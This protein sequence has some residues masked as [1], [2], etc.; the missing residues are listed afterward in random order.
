MNKQAQITMFIIVGLVILLLAIIGYV[1]FETDLI[2]KPPEAQVTSELETQLRP[3]TNVVAECQERILSEGAQILL[4]NGGYIDN[5]ALVATLLPQGNAVELPG[6]NT[7]P[8]WHYFES[9][10]QQ[11]MRPDLYGTNSQSVSQQLATYVDERLEA[12]I[13]WQNFPEY[14][15]EYSEYQSSLEF[16]D[17]QTTIVTAW[18]VDVQT[19]AGQRSYEEFQATIDAPILHLYDV[20]SEQINT[21]VQTST[22]ENNLINLLSFYATGASDLPPLYGTIGFMPDYKIWNLQEGRVELAEIISRSNNFMQVYGSSEPRLIASDQDVMNE[23]QFDGLQLSSYDVTQTQIDFYT[24]FEQLYYQVDKN[25]A[26]A[27]PEYQPRLPLIGA[28]VPPMADTNFAHDI[29]YPLIISAKKGDYELVAAYEANIRQTEPVYF[30]DD[31]GSVEQENLCTQ[32][33]G[34]QATI[35]VS[36][37][38]QAPLEQPVQILMDCQAVTCPLGETTTQIQTQLPTCSFAGISAFD[39]E[40]VSQTVPVDSQAGGSEEIELI[41]YEPQETTLQIR[42]REIVPTGENQY[43]AAP[44]SSPSPAEAIFIRKESPYVAQGVSGDTIELVPGTYDILVIR[45][46]DFEPAFTIPQEEVCEGDECTIIEEITFESLPVVYRKYEDVEIQTVQD[47]TTL[48]AKSLATQTIDGVE[49]PYQL[50]S[51]RELG[52]IGAL[53]DVEIDDSIN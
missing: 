27:I 6:G 14:D 29:T 44:T 32:P 20:V 2:F 37:F 47:E 28:F 4:K 24:P 13:P 40:L 52:L 31:I 21:F 45:M 33:G 5:P 22:P 41:L 8:Y 10:Q 17:H 46:L 9:N 30:S 25:P 53:F 39:S 48:I 50:V 7:I 36:R 49:K 26:V 35:R 43:S 51:Y 11:S 16:T 42:A 15:F 18:D 34:S 38:D 23:L 3:F 1:A 12:C 19:P